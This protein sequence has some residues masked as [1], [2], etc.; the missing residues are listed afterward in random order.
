[1]ICSNGRLIAPFLLS[2]L[3][4][5]L[6]TQMSLG[7]P[8]VPDK[9]T[10]ADLKVALL[11]KDLHYYYLAVDEHVAKGEKREEAMAEFS[12]AILTREK[13]IEEKVGF[14]V[15]VTYLE[16]E[17]KELRKIGLG[18]KHPQILWIERLLKELRP[19]VRKQTEQ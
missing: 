1:M 3:I 4:G 7:N 16:Q 18:P 12:H 9:F 11:L 6:G 19:K 10:Q 13:Q 17:L 2:S 15:M 14:A 8:V 5:I